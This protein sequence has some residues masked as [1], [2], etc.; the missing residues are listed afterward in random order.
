MHKC[1]LGGFFFLSLKVSKGEK[2]FQIKFKL[3]IWSLCHSTS[4]LYFS[5]SSFPYSQHKF[6][7]GTEMAMRDFHPFISF[8]AVS[9][10][11]QRFSKT[12][13]NEEKTSSLSFPCNWWLGEIVLKGK[14]LV[15]TTGGIS[16]FRSS[17]SSFEA[18]IKF[19]YSLCPDFTFLVTAK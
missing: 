19:I 7:D 2:L 4:P 1:F 6:S 3:L 10:P 5:F 9:A 15:R 14:F 13:R 12:R 8:G 18:T 11:R 17:S 16:I